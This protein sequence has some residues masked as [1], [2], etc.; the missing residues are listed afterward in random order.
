MLAGEKV[1]LPWNHLGPLS[2]L[3]FG[4]GHGEATEGR[5]LATTVLTLNG[6]AFTGVV[7]R[8]LRFL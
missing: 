1:V 7:G 2:L 5:I 3:G 8:P 6:W 4:L